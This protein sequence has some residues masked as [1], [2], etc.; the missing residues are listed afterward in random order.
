[1]SLNIKS[2]EADELVAE[3]ARLTGETKTQAVIE[4]LRQRLEREQARLERE[5]LA[6]DLLKIGKK[7]ASYGGD[8]VEHGELLYD[9]DGSPR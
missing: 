2:P 1:M 4:S 3:V 7:C 8:R 9:D 6:S 5:S